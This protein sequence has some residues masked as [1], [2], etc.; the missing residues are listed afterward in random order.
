ML[1]AKYYASIP[2]RVLFVSRDRAYVVLI[3]VVMSS[4]SHRHPGRG[5]LACT[6][7]RG[8]E[9]CRK[10]GEVAQALDEGE[11]GGGSPQEAEDQR[12]TPLGRIHQAARIE[13]RIVVYWPDYSSTFSY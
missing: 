5:G 12:E 13:P 6:G 7:V 11:G 9:G 1:L 8:E 10:G 4:I 2:L 3:T